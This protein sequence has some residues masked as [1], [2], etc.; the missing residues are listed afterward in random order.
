MFKATK[1]PF[2]WTMQ[3]NYNM[4][5]VNNVLE[6]QKSPISQKLNVDEDHL[7]FDLIVEYKQPQQVPAKEFFTIQTYRKLGK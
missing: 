7:N 5:R 1:N 2:C 4:S 6:P 3:C